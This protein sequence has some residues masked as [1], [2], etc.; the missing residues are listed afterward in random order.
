MVRLVIL[1]CLAVGLP[2]CTTKAKARAR[3]SA[4]YS[5]GQQQ[6]LGQ[7][8]SILAPTVSFVGNFT[9]PRLAWTEGLT[10]AQAIVA[11]DY[12]SRSSPHSI[13]VTR[14]GQR[15]FVDPKQLLNGQ[16]FALEAGDVIEIQ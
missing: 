13:F 1:L 9:H 12:R 3:A 2:G 5:A 16:D 10:L 14:R 4:A 6:A 11:A 7:L 15:S 8:Q